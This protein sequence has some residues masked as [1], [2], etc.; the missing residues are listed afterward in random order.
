MTDKEIEEARREGK[1]HGEMRT[2]LD[3]LKR[4]TGRLENA[5]LAVLT[6]AAGLWAKSMGFFQ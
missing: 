2:D 6:G 1:E 5:I 4:R 3:N